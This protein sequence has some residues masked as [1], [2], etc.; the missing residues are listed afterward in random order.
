M[1]YENRITRLTLIIELLSKGHSLS[2]PY[3]VQ[4]FGVTKKIVQTDFKEYLLPLY[5]DR[6]IYY[7]YIDKAYKARDNFLSKTFLSAEELAVIAILQNKAKDKYSDDDLALKTHALFQKLDNALSHRLYQESSIEK[8]DE[9]KKEIIQI[10]NAIEAKRVITC[11]YSNKEREVYPLKILNLE[12][13]WYLIVYEPASELLKTFHLNSVKEIVLTD[14]EYHFDEEKVKSFDNAITA[15][16]KPDNEPITVQLFI[17]TQISKYFQRKPLNKTQRIIEKYSDGSIDIEVLITDFMEIIPI[18][19][20]Y[21][22]YIG[23]IEPKEL[24]NEVK[25]NLEMALQQSK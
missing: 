5:E 7:C 13:Y 12:G 23:V 18:I 9:F 16:Y 6:T 10:N 24:K 2:T 17:D 20:R 4:K 25:K 8:I 19:Q 11:K 3:L 22:P 14:R 15:Y 21:I 1:H